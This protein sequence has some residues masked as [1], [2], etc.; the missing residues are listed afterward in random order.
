MKEIIGILTEDL[1]L[2][3]ALRVKDSQKKMEN[4]F[5][6]NKLLP[7]V[8]IFGIMAAVMFSII[9]ISDICNEQ[10]DIEEIREELPQMGVCFLFFVIGGG[11]ALMIDETDNETIVRKATEPVIETALRESVRNMNVTVSEPKD[12]QDSS[13]NATETG[14]ETN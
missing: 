4:R 13:D 5:L 6:R 12:E 9:T 8:L 1:T 7:F 14:I 10:K 2:D 11:F 3:K